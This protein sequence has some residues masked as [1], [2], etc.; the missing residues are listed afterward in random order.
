ML[1]HTRDFL[2]VLLCPLSWLYGAIESIISRFKRPRKLIVPVISVGNIHWGGTGKTPLVMALA[3]HFQRHRPAVVSSGFGAKLRYQGAKCSLDLSENGPQLF[4][5]EP[6]MIASLSRVDVYIGKNRCRVIDRYSVEKDHKLIILDDGFQHKEIDRTVNILLLP[7]DSSPWD[8][9]LIPLGNLREGF[10]SV[11][12]ADVVVISC[13]NEATE[14]VAEWK[15]LLSHFAPDKRPVVARREWNGVED[16]SGISIATLDGKWG[17]FCGIAQP[18][19]FKRDLESLGPISFFKAFPDHYSYQKKDIDELILSAKQIGLE[20]LITT[21]KDSFKVKSF[22][23]RSEVKLG[24]S[25]ICYQLPNDF[26]AD[27]ENRV[28]LIC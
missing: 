11:R 13:S 14:T 19:R 5:D 12:R 16:S 10:G 25:K 6:W 28:G 27:I 7:G 9:A 24:V 20:G 15:S 18:E 4:G 3:G 21:Q 8:S 22:F 1:Q 26:W 17:A 2:W 23:E